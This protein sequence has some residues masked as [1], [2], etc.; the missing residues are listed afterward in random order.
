MIDMDSGTKFTLVVFIVIIL[1]FGLRSCNEQAITRSWG[2]EMEV[3]LEPNQKL[4]EVTWKDSELWFLTKN[5][6]EDDIAEDYTFYEKDVNGILE[7]TV[8][9]HEL[10]MDEKEY[11]EYEN[12][13]KYRWDYDRPGNIVDGEEIFIHYDETTDTFSLIKNYEYSEDDYGTISLVE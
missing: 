13:N 12:Q 3:T 11:V 8:Y 5:M 1:F 6:K 9:I 7:G 10:K 2:G 4:L